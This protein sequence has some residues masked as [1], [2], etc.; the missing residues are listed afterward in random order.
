MKNIQPIHSI[1]VEFISPITITVSPRTMS[2]VI[3]DVVVKT[4]VVIH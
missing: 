3:S 4:I 2:P 1:R